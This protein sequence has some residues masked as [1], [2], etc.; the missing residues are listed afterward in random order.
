MLKNKLVSRNNKGANVKTVEAN[1]AQTKVVTVGKVV[2]P[3][4]R[5]KSSDRC[6]EEMLSERP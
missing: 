6:R 5:I 2:T 3:G 1:Y 4:V